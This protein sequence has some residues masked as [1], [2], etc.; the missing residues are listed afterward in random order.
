[1]CHAAQPLAMLR[2]RAMPLDACELLRDAHVSPMSMCPHRLKGRPCQP[3]RPG[4]QKEYAPG[5]SGAA[6]PEPLQP[7]AAVW[8]QVGMTAF[9]Q[10]KWAWGNPDQARLAQGQGRAGKSAPTK[11]VKTV[12]PH[13]QWHKPSKSRLHSKS[14]G[15][16]AQHHRARLVRLATSDGSAEPWSSTWLCQQDHSGPSG[17]RVTIDSQD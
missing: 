15:G 11:P 12:H 16:T 5:I 2:G 13:C 6:T 1:M 7:I 8:D 3:R 10:A 17:S 9:S 14:G 4:R